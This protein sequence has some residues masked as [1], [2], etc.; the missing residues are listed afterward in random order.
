MTTQEILQKCTVEEN[1][2]KLP[3]INL[4]RT[5][6][7]D[8]A[9]ALNKIGGK[10]KGG[11]IAGFVFDTDPTELLADIAGG[12][13]RNIKKEF[14]FFSTPANLGNTLVRLAKL[15]NGAKVLEPSAGD[16]ALIEEILTRDYDIDLHAIELMPQ[17][18]IKLKEKWPALKLKATF[19]FLAYSLDKK[20]DRIIA[21]PPFTKGQDIVHLK[22]MYE[23]LNEKGIVACITSIS[24]I[25]GQNKKNK[26]FRKWLDDHNFIEE[27]SRGWR[28]FEN[29]GTDTQFY[30]KN[31]DR[32]YIEM[33]DAGTFKE[34]GTN[35][36]TA[37]IVIEKH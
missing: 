18:S 37:I 22:K 16:G 28:M 30:R 33:I 6:Y 21:N 32:V 29:I 23:H 27:E 35:V 8:V 19:D 31:G 10:W 25:S 26:E 1:T 34:S 7:Q 12:I 15:F 13:K 17:N 14:Q 5:T 4:D 3:N 11:K 24:W 36:R 2:V 9:K 20:F